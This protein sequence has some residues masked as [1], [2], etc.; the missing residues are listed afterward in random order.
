VTRR[1]L[2]AQGVSP[3][4]KSMKIQTN[5]WKKPPQ[6]EYAHIVNWLAEQPK[7]TPA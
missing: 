3:G 4:K 6:D 5:T 2:G 7:R 1:G